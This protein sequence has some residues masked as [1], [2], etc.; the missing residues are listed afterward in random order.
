MSPAALRAT[1][2]SSAPK[3]IRASST[4]TI[5]APA[6]CSATAPAR[7]CSCRPTE[8]GILSAHLH[9]DGTLQGHPVRARPG[10]PAAPSR[11]R[12]SCTWTGSAV[13][14][15]AVK[16][17]AEVAHEALAAE[18]QDRRRHRLADPA[19]GE[20]P[21]H[22]CDG[23]EARPAARQGDLDRR[24]ARATRRRHRF[25]WR[26]TSRCATDA[27]SAGQHLMLVGV[28]GGFTWG[29]VL[30]ALVSARERHRNI[31]RHE[32]RVRVSR[33]GLAADRHDGRLRR[34]SGRCARRSPK[35]PKCSGDDLWSARRSTGPEGAQPDA[36]HA[37]RDADGRR[38]RLAR[39]AGGG[40][41]RR[42]RSSPV[43]ASANTRRWSRRVRSTSR[44]PC[45]WCAF[46]REAMQE[47]VPAGVGAM[48]AVLGADDARGRATRAAKRRRARSSSR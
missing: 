18:S 14:K 21:H 19:S 34:P 47:A 36:Q 40:R 28:G 26:S 45:R 42:R 38:R 23:E 13:F 8:P 17:L 6:C 32:R 20:H 46:A 11:E 15:F 30:R 10:E 35:R 25:R 5:A 41:R 48:A 3:S 37:A 27:S 24:P 4:G 1:R 12:R 7:S 22:G 39:V 31:D 43:T 29:S 33:A 9:A 16:V 44:T 2:S